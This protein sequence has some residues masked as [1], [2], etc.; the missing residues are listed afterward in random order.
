MGEAE[1]KQRE[2]SHLR[3]FKELW[4]PLGTA[5]ILDNPC[6]RPDF[7]ASLG[8]LRI[9]IEHTEILQGSGEEDGSELRKN[10][11]NEDRL[12]RLACSKYEEQGNPPVDVS[13]L[14]HGHTPVSPK[15]AREL[16]KPVAELVASYLPEEGDY[17]F[18]RYPLVAWSTLPSEIS[19]IRIARLDGCLNNSW[20]SN[21]AHYPP[22][23]SAGDVALA[24]N[25]KETLV[26][27]YR[28]AC[29][30]LWLLLVVDGFAPSG[31]FLRDPEIPNHRFQSSFDELFLL[32]HF[33]SRV[34][35]L[36]RAERDRPPNH[37]RSTRTADAA[38]ECQQRSSRNRIKQAH[39]EDR[40]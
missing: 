21:R 31:D 18:V 34:T 20:H 13:F 3:R 33:D 37:G 6:L 11:S 5:E 17:V 30:E 7:I 40:K 16:A 2:C 19:S 15:R 10:E 14:W 38:G 22:T 35:R 36:H 8:G 39:K 9:G 29:D 25:R 12:V 32:E 4:T 28:K 23:L 1:K 26:Q 24:V 27:E